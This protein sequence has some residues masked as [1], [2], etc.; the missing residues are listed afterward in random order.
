MDKVA[1]RSVNLDVVEA[2]LLT[3]I[4]GFSHELLSS[5]VF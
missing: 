3:S 2:D 5:R 1:M 4:T